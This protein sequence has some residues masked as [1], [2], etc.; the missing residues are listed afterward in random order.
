MNSS[1]T[2]VASIPPV[3][4]EEARR[5]AAAE[6]GRLVE[7]FR[8]LSAEDWTKPTDCPLWD[9]R[10]MAG[11][12]VGMMNDFSGFRKLMPRMNAAG[13]A[14]KKSGGVFIDVLTAMQVADHAE[15]TSGQLIERAAACAPRAARFRGSANGL[16]RRMP[17]KEEVDGRPETWRM[18]YLL[19]TILTRDP[20]MHRV[21]IARATGRE[22][23]LSPE[24]DGRLVADVVAEWA[25]RHGQPFTLT[26]TGPAGGEYV[27]GGGGE[28]ITADAVEFCRMLSGRAEGTGLLARPVPF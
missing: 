4:R 26:L 25:R 11:H 15:L 3:S 6:Y 5:L 1:V 17:L 20:W 12:C 28:P 21:D 10:A 14:A 2:T 27:S 23:V 24:H 13:K 9:V 22:M 18:G 8:A 7:A 16:F 19:D